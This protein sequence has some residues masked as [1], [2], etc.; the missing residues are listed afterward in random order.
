MTKSGRFS[1]RQ[2]RI[3]FA[4]SFLGS[5]FDPKLRRSADPQGGVF[6][7]RFRQSDLTFGPDD[8]F[9]SFPR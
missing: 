4:K 3:S 9:Q 6:C 7:E 1:R 5:R 8:F 2:N